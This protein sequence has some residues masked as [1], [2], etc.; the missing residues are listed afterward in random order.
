M[1]RSLF[2]I[3]II[4]VVS[5][6]SS[7]VDTV[8]DEQ[9]SKVDYFIMSDEDVGW[10]IIGGDLYSVNSRG[11]QWNKTNF[12]G[13]MDES[14]LFVLDNN[15][16]YISKS[17]IS[18]TTLLHTM[19]QGKTW[20]ESPALEGID[21]VIYFISET[22]GWVQTSVGAA[23]ISLF[24]STM[25]YK[26][27]DLIYWEL[28]NQ[29]DGNEGSIPE[30]GQKLGLTLTDQKR[31][32]LNVAVQGHPWILLSTDG[33][34]SWSKQLLPHQADSSSGH[35]RYI[36]DKPIFFG[37]DALLFVEST[38]L[39]DSCLII[40]STEDYGDTWSYQSSMVYGDSDTVSYSFIDSK[41]GWIAISN[42]LYQTHDGGQ[43]WERITE[44]EQNF[45]LIQFTSEFDGWALID[46][47]FMVTKDG[48]I[49]WSMV[50]VRIEE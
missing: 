31:G 41:T 29:T 12:K 13:N 46:Q 33:G 44:G 4:V 36:V 30:E 2:V 27:N 18:S 26:T 45:N 25:L 19:D 5:G 22:E 14:M 40:Y 49:T 3:C 7:H 34:T 35:Q 15:T 10:G 39:D 20:R 21:S 38:C 8:N 43:N 1:I 9:P 37:N 6:C 11:R 17:N 16:A 48:G 23:S 42:R 24:E 28:I 32:W 47:Y 50:D